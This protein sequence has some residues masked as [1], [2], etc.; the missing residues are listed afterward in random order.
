LFTKVERLISS[1]NLRPKKKE[2][3]LKIISVFSF[4]GIMLGVAILI[5]VMSVMNGFKTDLTKKI[6]GLN[7]HIVIEPN[8]FLIDDEYISKL[9][10]EFQDIQ[11]N[12][13]FSGEGIIINNDNAKGVILKG[14]NKD[15]KKSIEFIKKNIT[16]GNVKAFKKNQVF[17]GTELAY[18]LNLKEGD[19]INLMSSAFVATPLGSL[20][21]QESFKIAGTFTTGFIE[22]DQNIV[23]LGIEDALSIFDKDEKDKN[24]EI[25]L[26]DP[27]KANLI[28]NKIE[29][30]NPNYFIYTWSDL[31]KSFFS[32]LK[33]ERNVMFIILTLIVIVAA[34]NIISGLT[35]LIKNKTKEIAILKT[36]GL[37]NN[38]I[39]KSFFLTGF[40]IGFFATLSG[41]IIGIIFSYNIEK[42]RVILSSVFNLEIFPPD[43]YFL[44]KLPSE[45]NILSIL[46]IFF[47]SLTVTAI[48]SYLP[49]MTI[50]KMKTFRAL[51][52]E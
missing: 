46:I 17:L 5:I 34:F 28:K 32:A 49:A 48:A 47:L 36:L 42:L 3:F 38:S 29:K 22:F 16:S 50:S 19:K 13:S 26:N 21:K 20:P 7:P 8:S 25:Y 27:L 6:L 18:N 45:I 40:S 52:Y 14:I 1:R 12:K 10:N 39:K 11:I 41:I 51:K 30:I 31:N 24:L 23:F 4:L 43:I 37:S 9:K 15:E 33:V 44:E 2:G 35:I